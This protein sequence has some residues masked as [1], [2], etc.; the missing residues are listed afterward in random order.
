MTPPMSIP[1]QS[2]GVRTFRHSGKRMQTFFVVFLLIQST[3]MLNDLTAQPAFGETAVNEELPDRLRLYG[4][5]QFLFGLDAKIR[6]D[7]DNTG[8]GSTTNVVDDLGVEDNDSMIRA[9]ARFRFNENHAIG[10]SWYD[11]NLSGSQTIDESLQIDD[12]IFSVG[13]Q[14]KSKIDLTL[15]RLHYNWSFYH[16]DQIEMTLSPGVYIGD[17]NARFKG[18]AVIDSGDIIPSAQ[19]RTVR[20]DFLTPLPA[21]G[22]ALYYDI[23]PRLTASIRTDFFYVNIDDVNGGMLDTL[24]GLEY[25]VFKHFAVGVAYNLLILDLEYESGKSDGGKLDASWNSGLFYGA[26]YF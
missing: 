3:L 6:L 23:L 12:K 22:L 2:G 17:F 24:V 16:N 10:F 15:Y 5:Y 20:E 11:I 9:G 8:S 13:S 1:D 25:R 7:G 21:V 4:G 26:L 19:Q 18:T 14:V